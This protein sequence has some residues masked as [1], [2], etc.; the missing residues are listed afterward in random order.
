MTRPAKPNYIKVMRFIVAIG[1]VGFDG[2]GSL[3]LGTIC[4]LCQFSSF[5]GVAYLDMSD[6][7]NPRRRREDKN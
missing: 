2:F 4:R 3:A 1:M 6:C 7:N 5:D